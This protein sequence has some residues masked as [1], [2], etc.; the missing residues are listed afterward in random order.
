MYQYFTWNFGIFSTF[1]KLHQQISSTSQHFCIMKKWSPFTSIVLDKCFV[2]SNASPTAPSAEW[3]EVNVHFWMNYP[4]NVKLQNALKM[5]HL[6]NCKRSVAPLTR[7]VAAATHRVHSSGSQDDVQQVCWGLTPSQGGP[8]QHAGH[9]TNLQ[10][11]KT[12]AEDFIC[13]GHRWS[14]AW[15]HVH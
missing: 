10:L 2:D 3:W 4:F 9:T 1:T 15:T 7:T 13:G 6:P 5:T 12:F 8:L 14:W 11:I